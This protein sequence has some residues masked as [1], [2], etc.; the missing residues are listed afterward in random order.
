[1]CLYD[2]CQRFL[3]YGV[4]IIKRKKSPNVKK[5]LAPTCQQNKTIISTLPDV[6]GKMLE[7][8]ANYHISNKIGPHLHL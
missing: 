7:I 1:M 8:S 3:L 5:L 4:I 2:F 6:N